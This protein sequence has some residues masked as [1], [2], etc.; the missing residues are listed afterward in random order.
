MFGLLQVR[1]KITATIFL[2]FCINN[3]F[4]VRVLRVYRCARG[5]T[6]L[7]DANPLVQWGLHIRPVPLHI[8]PPS[9]GAAAAQWTGFTRWLVFGDR[10]DCPE[11]LFRTESPCVLNGK[12]GPERV[13]LH[14]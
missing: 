6:F 8:L 14:F 9:W 10:A 13:I 2:L 5:D 11:R 3:V 4:N 12:S 7:Q 1:K